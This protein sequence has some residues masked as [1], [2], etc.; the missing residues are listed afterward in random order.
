MM[1]ELL[2]VPGAFGTFGL[3]L[4]IFGLAPGFVLAGIVRL[5]PDRDRRRELQAELYDVPRWEQPFWVVQQLEVAIRIGLVP[6]MSWYWGRWV[7]H[8][9]KI[10]SGLESHH[11]YPN[12]FEI[13]NSEDK[14]ELRPGDAVRLM[15]SVKR[16]PAAGERMWV[17]IIHRDGD[18]LV[19]R[20]KS[21]PFFVHLSPDEI[22]KFHIDD[23]I[24]CTFEGEEMLREDVA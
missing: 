9:C 20:L 10:E 19:G 21:W 4:L 16:Y 14:A 23:I 2:S 7:W 18:R 22:V 13:P 12:T 17:E 3:A 6:E 1:G 15:W 5:I 11:R 8:R 24:D